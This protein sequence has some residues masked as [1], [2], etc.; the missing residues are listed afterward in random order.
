MFDYKSGLSIGTYVENFIREISGDTKTDAFTNGYCFHFAAILEKMFD[1][2]IMYDPID[3]HFAFLLNSD[4]SLY[5]ASGKIGHFTH[6]LKTPDD[7]PCYN[8]VPTCSNY[9]NKW[10]VW[11]SFKTL[12]PIESNR[13]LEEC[14]YKIRI[15]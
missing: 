10:Y 1:G 15:G 11:D 12:E 14:V 9:S 5:D 13:I 4:A 3:N 7:I 8:L 2:M 6:I